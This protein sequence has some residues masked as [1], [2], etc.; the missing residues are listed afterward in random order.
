[1]KPEVVKILEEIGGL[2]EAY[3]IDQSAFARLNT[4]R[5]LA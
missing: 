1:M 4:F 2:E 5:E 3:E